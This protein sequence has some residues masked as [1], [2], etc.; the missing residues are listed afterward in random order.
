MLNK[1]AL[2]GAPSIPPVY[3]ED[4]FSTYLYT[5]N[6][7]TTTINNG[8]D[9]SGKGGLVWIKSRTN[10][11]GSTFQHRLV[12]TAR[13]RFFGLQLGGANGNSS[14]D[15]NGLNG[16][17]FLS[18][19]FSV[20]QGGSTN[21]NNAGNNYCSWSFCKQ[22]KF[23]DV[24]TWIGNSGTQNISHSLGSTP[25]MIWV[26][27]TDTASNW[28]CYHRSLSS[29]FILYPNT[30]DAQD[31][32]GSIPQNTFGNNSVP[33][34]PTNTVFT[35]G[36]F[37]NASGGTYVAYL[38]AHD[39]GGFGTSG[40]DNVISCGSFTG[41]GPATIN[42]GYE[43]QWLLIKSATNADDWYMFDTMRGWTANFSGLNY[44]R[45][46]SNAAE[47]LNGTT[48]PITSTGFQF[49]YG[50]GQTF[51]YMAIRRPMKPPTSGTEVFTP[52]TWTGNN[53]ARKITGTASPPDLTLIR[54]R[55]DA[56]GYSFVVNDR[57][58]GFSNVLRTFWDNDETPGITS[59][60]SSFNM[61]GISLGTDTS[62][63]GYN[64]SPNPEIGLFLT[65]RPRFLDIV[66]YTGDGSGDRN[67]THNL[68][69]VPELLIYKRRNASGNWEVI[70]ND[71]T[72]T[73]REY[74]LNFNSAGVNTGLPISGYFGTPT[75][76]K[77]GSSYLSLGDG[78]NASGGT[79]VSY[80]FASCPGVSKVGSYTGNGSNQ[81][82]NCGFSAGARFV[83]IKRTDS[84][85]D[86]YVWDTARGIV[87][88]N[89]AHLSLNTTAAEVT[90]DD[91]IDPDSSGFIVNQ[92]S[93][94]NINVSSATYIFL[95]IA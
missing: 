11:A 93:A 73:A 76:F 30:T 84:T 36:L 33:V 10:D 66:C 89:D 70:A 44:L 71:T 15:G 72:G 77:V 43:P 85:G 17:S 67:V 62:N 42:L 1:K 78:Y 55:S 19:G 87:S 79:Y 22:P 80:L 34:A 18:N 7:G 3:V 39:A 95:A 37:L 61:D 14:S 56:T 49:N 40:A 60:I 81:T 94:T 46:N 27:R 50:A 6:D 92:L 35:T 64:K 2:A 21:L 12:D 58:R 86:W 82:I 75:T 52:I 9:F 24:V 88:G 28:N 26:K 90:T 48:T 57:L 65:R 91:S 45:A 63:Y 83:L 54:D 53:T 13:G 69:A 47:I 4:F 23:F 5:G 68:N 20:V 25:G 41:A 31:N 59:G 51:I 38:F 74:F 16:G 32:F 8:I 29:G